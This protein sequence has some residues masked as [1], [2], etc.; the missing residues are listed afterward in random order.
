MSKELLPPDEESVWLDLYTKWFFRRWVLIAMGVEVA[1]GLFIW[2]ALG[3]STTVG[4]FVAFFVA[5]VILCTAYIAGYVLWRDERQDKLSIIETVSERDRA[6]DEKEDRVK[7]LERQQRPRIIGF[8]RQVA[9]HDT[10]VTEQRQP[11]SRRVLGPKWAGSRLIVKI[12][13]LN[14]SPQQ[15]TISDARLRIRTKDGDENR[16]SMTD[17]IKYFGDSLRTIL[18]GTDIVIF[19]IHSNNVETLLNGLIDAGQMLESGRRYESVVVFDLAG[20]R[21]TE[22]NRFTDYEIELDDAWGNAHPIVDWGSG[23]VKNNA[24]IIPWTPDDAMVP[25]EEE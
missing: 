20:V 12:G 3:L 7:Y 9:W 24:V 23:R 22:V 11:N 25:E 15:T 1:L 8:I 16:V 17:D 5:L 18:S 21:G 2:G 19:G 14:E 13:F 10:F 6:L 4:S